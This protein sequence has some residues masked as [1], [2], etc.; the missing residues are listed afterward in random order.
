MSLTE[1]IH[2]ALCDKELTFEELVAQV[3]TVALALPLSEAMKRGEIVASSSPGSPARYRATTQLEPL[4]L[5]A[6]P[7]ANWPVPSTPTKDQRLQDQR[8]IIIDLVEDAHG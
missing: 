3:G 5:A 7:G 4:Y 1:K 2:A 8:V 6:V